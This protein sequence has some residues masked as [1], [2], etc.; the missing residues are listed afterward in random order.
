MSNITWYSTIPLNPTIGDCVMDSLSGKDYT[1]SGI[2]WMEI[3]D[4]I[5]TSPLEMMVPT[6]EQLDTYPALK[7]AWEQYVIVKKLIGR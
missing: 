6:Q 4:L 2:H 5:S 3:P 1:W 7:E